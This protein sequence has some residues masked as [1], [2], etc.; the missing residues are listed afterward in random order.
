MEDGLQIDRHIFIARQEG[1]P[2]LRQWLLQQDRINKIVFKLVKPV[3][4]NVVI[5]SSRLLKRSVQRYCRCMFPGTEQVDFDK[6]HWAVEDFLLV[7]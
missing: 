2:N 6:V 4:A 3:N 1:N 7:L 5:K